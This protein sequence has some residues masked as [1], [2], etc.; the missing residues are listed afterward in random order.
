MAAQTPSVSGETNYL[1]PSTATVQRRGLIV[2]LTP[3]TVPGRSTYYFAD[4]DNADTYAQTGWYGAAPNARFLSTSA[5]DAVSVTTAVSGST[6]T[7]TFVSAADDNLGYLILEPP[8][9][10]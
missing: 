7:A 5:L 3:N 10:E 1:D 2:S 6:M 4:I 9:V 8:S